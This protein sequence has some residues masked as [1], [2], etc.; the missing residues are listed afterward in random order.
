MNILCEL[1][2]VC[3]ASRIEYERLPVQMTNIYETMWS[4]YKDTNYKNVT[5]PAARPPIIFVTTTNTNY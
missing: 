3:N 4:D 1:V 5:L 2:L